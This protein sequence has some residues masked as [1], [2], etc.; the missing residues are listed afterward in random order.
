MDGSVNLRNRDNV[1]AFRISAG[2]FAIISGLACICAQ[3]F[4]ASALTIQI[5]KLSVLYM[6]Y[7]QC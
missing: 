6:Q 4:C 7:I 3:L 1:L 5:H 2:V